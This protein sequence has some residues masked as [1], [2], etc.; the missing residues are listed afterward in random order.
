MSYLEK[1]LA[2]LDY[3]YVAIGYVVL[4]A[5]LKPFLKY[6]ETARGVDEYWTVLMGNTKKP[7]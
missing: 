3:V 1:A 5:I 2:W 6:S 7:E 4:K